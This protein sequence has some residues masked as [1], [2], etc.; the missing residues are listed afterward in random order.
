VQWGRKEKESEKVEASADTIRCLWF[1]IFHCYYTAMS[2]RVSNCVCVC[3]SHSQSC[4]RQKEREVRMRK[5]KLTLPLSSFLRPTAI[6]L[7]RRYA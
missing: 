7:V 1:H 4:V 5:E 3:V 6:V 2:Y